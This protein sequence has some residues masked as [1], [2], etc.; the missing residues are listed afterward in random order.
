MAACSYFTLSFASLLLL[1]FRYLE[2]R[3]ESLMREG[4]E[5]REGR[6]IYTALTFQSPSRESFFIRVKGRGNDS[7]PPSVFSGVLPRTRGLR[8][9]VLL[10]YEGDGYFLSCSS[11]FL[12]YR[13]F[14]GAKL[15]QMNSLEKHH[16]VEDFLEKSPLI[17]G[18]RKK[19]GNCGGRRKREESDK[20]RGNGKG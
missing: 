3:A 19:G 8:G 2:P 20:C 7:I 15:K 1:L 11:K 14:S 17:R 16:T 12:V 6:P 18:S 4:F 10:Y 13:Y 9:L 5:R